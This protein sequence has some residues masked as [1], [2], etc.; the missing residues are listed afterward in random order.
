MCFSLEWIEHILIWLVVVIAIVLVIKVFLPR[1]LGMLGEGGNMVM[2][3]INIILWAIVVIAAILVGFELLSC[4][5]SS[6]G[7]SLSPPRH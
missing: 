6:T 5:I 2:A 1:L 4:L 7:L 3:V